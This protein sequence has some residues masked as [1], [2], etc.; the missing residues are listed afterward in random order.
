MPEPK[1]NHGHGSDVSLPFG[2]L[3]CVGVGGT[4]EEVM[5]VVVVVKD[6]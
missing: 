2:S 5:V 4:R 1:A 3:D 6:S